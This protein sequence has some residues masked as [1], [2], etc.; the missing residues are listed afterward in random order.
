MATSVEIIGL[1][2]VKANE[3]VHL[4]EIM[5]KNSEG[6]FGIIKFTQEIPTEPKDNWQ[7]P[8]DEK[9]LNTEGD[10]IVADG[11]DAENKPELWKG[12]VRLAFFFHYLDLSKPLKTPFGDIVLPKESKRPNRLSIMEYEE[13]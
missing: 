2:P 4:L 8:Y 12:D 1:H 6:I 13:P 7:V 3:P 5:V 10:E 11:F 9:I